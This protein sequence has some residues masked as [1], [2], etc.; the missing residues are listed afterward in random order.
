MITLE[1]ETKPLMR[2][3]RYNQF[4][5]T[6]MHFS[7]VWGTIPTVLRIPSVFCGEFP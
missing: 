4:P 6:V 5:K 3:V 7:F 2:D 1:D